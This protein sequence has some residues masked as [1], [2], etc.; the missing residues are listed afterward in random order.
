MG[1][2]SVETSQAPAA[3]RRLADT[4]SSDTALRLIGAGTSDVRE[5]WRLRSAASSDPG[6]GATPRAGA[7]GG[8]HPG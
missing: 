3:C 5:L 1:S 6:A 2:M 8:D 4:V 7:T